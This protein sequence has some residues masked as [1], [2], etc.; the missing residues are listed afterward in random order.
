MKN[1]I[2]LQKPGQ[3]EQE[4]ILQSAYA[5]MKLI[6]LWM[7]NIFYE[8]ANE[9]LKNSFVKCILCAFIFIFFL[10]NLIKTLICLMQKSVLKT[11]CLEASENAII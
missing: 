4:T 3:D 6:Q 11:K 10:G 9:L 5:T 8:T 1:S 7:L 2:L